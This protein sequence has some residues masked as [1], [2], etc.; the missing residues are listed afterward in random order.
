MRAI[1]FR[2]VGQRL[3]LAHIV[4]HLFR[5]ALEQPA[6]AHGE[7][8][9]ADKGQ[10]FRRNVKGDMTGGMGRHVD[11]LGGHVA[12]LHRVAL[13]DHRVEGRDAFLLSFRAGDMATGGILDRGIAAGVVGVPVGVPYLG[14]GPAAFL[15][16]GQHRFG[17]RRINHHGLLRFGLVNQPDIIVG[18]DGNA[19]DL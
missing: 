5:R 8:G 17:H 9:V 6:A 13:P 19:D 3:Q 2:A 14:D 11:H 4:I 18:Q 1:D 16:F 15:G 12:E 10:L 7:Q